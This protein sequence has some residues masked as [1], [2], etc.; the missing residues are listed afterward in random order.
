MDT[1]KLTLERT[2]YTVNQL[3][4]IGHYYCNPFV[5]ARDKKLCFYSNKKHQHV[6]DIFLRFLKHALCPTPL[7][8]TFDSFSFLKYRI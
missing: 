4:I 7:K 6:I 5:L 3:P 2:L 1:Q 8:S